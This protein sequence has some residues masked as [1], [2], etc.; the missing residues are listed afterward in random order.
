MGLENRPY[1][2]TWRLDSRGLVQHTPDALVYINGDTSLPGCPKCNGRINIQKFITEISVDA[3]TDPGAASASFTL[4]IPLHHGDSFARDAQFILRPGQEVHIYKRGYFPVK[5]LYSGLSEQQVKADLAPSGDNLGTRTTGA[6]RPQNVAGTVA[7]TA[8]FTEVEGFKSYKRRKPPTSIV[9]HESEGSTVE[10][11]ERVLQSRQLGVHYMIGPDGTV[12]QYMDPMTRAT[13]HLKGFNDQS[14]GIEVVN[15][16]YG[17]RAAEGQVVINAPW[18]YGKKG[19]AVPPLAQLE[20][21]YSTTYYLSQRPDSKV[22]LTFPGV[23]G[24]TFSFTKLKGSSAK[25]PGVISHQNW[26]AHADGSFPTLYMVLRSRGMLPK[27]AYQKAIELAQQ[28]RQVQLPPASWLSMASSIPAPVAVI[29]RNPK[30]KVKVEPKDESH[31]H[32]DDDHEHD[33]EENLGSFVVPHLPHEETAEDRKKN[34]LVELGSSLLDEYGLAGSDVDNVLAYPYYHVFRGVVTQVGHSYSGG[35][36]TISVQCSSLLHFWQYHTMSTNASVFGARPD[37]SKLKLSMVGHNFTAMHPYQII[38]TLH[39]DMVGAAGGVGWALS[40]KTNQSAKSEIGGESLYSLNVQYWEQRFKQRMTK[41]RMHGASGELFSTA[42]AA[43]LSRLSSSELTRVVRNRF[44]DPTTRRGKDLGLLESALSVGLLKDRKLQ[45]LLWARKS[46]EA[47]KNDPSFEINLAE[48]QAFVSDI[49]QWGQLN[50]FESAYESKLDIAQKVCEVTGFEFYQD[51]DGD[52]VFKPPF[53][54]LD[55]SSSRV[56]CIEDLDI[57]SINFDEKE[58]EATYVTVKNGHFQNMAGTGVENEWGHRG[59]YIDYRLVAQFGWRP[60]DFE[61]SYFNDSRSLFFSAINRL[62]RL[63]ASVNSATLTIPIRPEIRPGYPVYIRYLDCFYYCNSLS[64]SYSVGGQCTTTLQLIAKR[65]KFFAPGRVDPSLKGVEAIDL[66]KTTLP[67]RPLEVLGDDGKPRL[68]GFP[69]VVMALD[70]ENIN[71]LFFIVGTDIEQ[72]DDP[73]TLRNLLKKAAS[74]NIGVRENKDGTYTM[75]VP[76]AKDAEGNG[77][78]QEVVFY[79]GNVP[80]KARNGVDILSAG[81]AYAKK[82]RE[83]GK[84]QDK[85]Q[86]ALVSL[87]DEIASLT[88]QIGELDPVRDRARIIELEGKIER[89]RRQAD[90]KVSQAQGAEAAFKASLKADVGT[91]VAYLVDLLQRFD[92]WNETQNFPD[93]NST[94]ALLDMLSDKKAILSNGTQPG[95]YRYYSASD[96]RPE[97]QGQAITDYVMPLDGKNPQVSSRNSFLDPEWQGITVRGFVPQPT[98]PYPGAYRAEAAF[99]EVQ[100]TRGIRVLTSNPHKPSGEVLPTNAIQ[101]LMFSVQEVL[102]SNRVGSLAKDMVVQDLGVYAERALRSLFT[103]KGTNQEPTADVSLAEFYTPLWEAEHSALMRAFALAAAEA[104]SI[105]PGVTLPEPEWDGVPDAVTINGVRVGLADNLKDTFQFEGATGKTSFGKGTEIWSAE[106]VLV[107]GGEALAVAFYQAASKMRSAWF[108][109]IQGENVGFDVPEAD[110]IISKVNEFLASRWG[111]PVQATSRSWKT[112]KKSIQSKVFSPVFPVSDERG[113]QVFGTYRYGRGVSIEPGGVWDA[114]AA[115]D[116]LG[117]LDRQTVEQVVDVF[118]RRK[119]SLVADVEKTL[120]NGKVVKVGQKVTGPEAVT[121]VEQKVIDSLRENL[122]DRQILD[123]DLAEIGDNPNMLKLRLSNWF[124]EDSKE[125]I[126]KIPVVNAAYSLA[127][128]T[129]HTNQHV[130]DCKAAEADILIDAFGQ[131][132]FLEV[133]G[134]SGNMPEGFGTSYSDRV[135]NWLMNQSVRASVD[136]KESQDALRGQTLQRRHGNV[137]QNFQNN[138]EALAQAVQGRTDRQ[139]RAEAALDAAARQFSDL[140]NEV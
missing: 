82:Q 86:E 44:A 19:Y 63:N 49:G 6:A 32:D 13:G 129:L 31:E 109:A 83:V 52:F 94:H 58:P 118:V 75:T 74:L 16:Y 128:L 77:D 28:G 3:G 43:Y 136:W 139:K 57:I 23:Q 20:A 93:K 21:L 116:P 123:L 40:Q 79:F 70:P 90:E 106:K 2:G 42:Q 105:K 47:G 115:Q 72:I 126:H 33:D 34:Q 65:A 67:Q 133:D 45:A 125:G 4:S 113:Y 71:P 12:Y 80:G 18:A 114:L 54:N 9:I 14:I 88:V 8:E 131:A 30:N 112:Q 95:S 101:E 29:P 100:P 140:A 5:G 110:R 127:D 1:V 120:A 81:K 104:E 122:T 132:D 66:S 98:L 7:S 138:I 124:S 41:L 108:R 96:P 107:K 62:D 60:A 35:T 22:P 36:N 48:M 10:G 37:N 73:V 111:V 102:T 46:K 15:P 103:P 25:E 99:G 11:T 24:D 87:N 53:Y 135:N 97:H 51:V 89:T 92:E 84:L 134:P 76:T 69:N 119:G 56:Y 61:T 78:A 38:Y 50:L 137:A 55:T 64:H 17:T 130:C 59:Q 91:G 85:R 68:A 39:H 27:D 26:G 117:M 121:Y